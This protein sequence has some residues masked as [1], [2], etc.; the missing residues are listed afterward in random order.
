MDEM[1]FLGMLVMAI[2]TLGGFVAVITKFTQPL[3]EVR[4]AIQKLID[5]LDS[6]KEADDK[7]DK[8]IAKHSEQIED[9]DN[10]MGKAETKIQLYHKE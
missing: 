8:A 7:R 10:R 5:R 1:Q 4:V 2:I 6:M 3:N 9:L